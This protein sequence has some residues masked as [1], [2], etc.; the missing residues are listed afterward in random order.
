[1]EKNQFIGFDPASVPSPCFVIDEAALRRNLSI[2]KEVQERSGATILLALKA[3]ACWPLFPLI[4]E[5]LPGICA[6]GPH[7]ARLGREEFGGQVHTYSPGYT[8]E[9]LKEVLELSD[10]IIFN[11]FGQWKRYRELCRPWRE[12]RSFGL[13]LNPRQ[14]EA[15]VALYDPSSPGSRLGIIREEFRPE[16]LEGIKGFHFHNLCEQGLEPLQRTLEAIEKQFGPWIGEM[17]WINFGGGHHIT[18]P[19]Y[20]R[21]GLIR[22]IRDFRERYG[23]EVILEPGEAAAIHTGIL[24]S[25]VLDVVENEKPS[26]VLDASV[27]C[28]MPDVIEMP[29]R[30]EV[31]G[32][33]GE[34]EKSWDAYLGGRSCLAGDTAGIYSFDSPLTRGDRVIFDDMSH[35]TMVKTTTFN[36]VPLPSIALY[37][38]E[39]GK[40]KVIRQFGYKE[41]KERLG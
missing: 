3:F 19:D 35:Y 36:G 41:F 26:V 21:E 18:K 28:H 8:E 11:S 15:D 32:A 1:M 17:E 34:G 23:V 13:R 29:Y 24:V 30:P 37:S 4:R 7:E 6:S 25:T 10:H 9:D 2:L 27:S 14:S 33:G 31:W 39:T 22:V 12:S 16:E 5:Y 40:T 20:D 38:P